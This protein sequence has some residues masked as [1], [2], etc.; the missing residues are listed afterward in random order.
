MSLLNMGFSASILILVIIIIRTLLLHKLPKQTFMIL[1]GVVLCRLLIPFE[2]PSRF[3]I[4]SILPTLTGKFSLESP[5]AGSSIAQNSAVILEAVT[6]APSPVA[7]LSLSLFMI[8]WLIGLIAGAMF[9]LVTHLR[10]RREYKTALPVDNALVTLWKKEH[11]LWRSVQIR[12]CDRIAAPLTYGIIRPVVLLPK[13]TDWTNEITLRYIL[14]HEYVHIRRFDT[15]RKLIMVTA[16]CIHWFNPLVW[17]MY[18]LSNRDIEL[19]CDEAVVKG[20]QGK[21]KSAYALALIDLEE[22]KSGF[23]PLVNNFSKNAIEE[24]VQSIMLYKKNSLLTILISIVFVAGSITA[25]LTPET[26]SG[27][28]PFNQGK[29]T[30]DLSDSYRSFIFE[31]VELSY[32]DDGHPYLHDIKTNNTDKTIIEIEYGMLG[33]DVSGNPVKLQ[34]NFLDSSANETYE[35]LVKEELGILPQETYDTAGG[36]SLYDSEKMDWPEINGAGPNKVAH[37]LYQIKKITFEDGTIWNNEDYSNWLKTYRGKAVDVSALRDYYP[38]VVE[39][40][41]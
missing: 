30:S 35:F 7:Y 2:I 24:R 28:K 31:S 16:L 1:W 10:C 25:V 20:F 23:M 4:Y 14:T 11:P 33:Y 40:T 26:A 13:Q 37:A 22:K 17:L 6:P 3:S 9:F 27:H 12:Q 39:I 15:L 21:A 5:L 34:W 32:Y 19:S 36:W 41:Q 8:I 29:S 38:N 18:V